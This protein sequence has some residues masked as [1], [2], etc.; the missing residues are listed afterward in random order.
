MRA[1]WKEE[2]FKSMGRR[3]SRVSC[4]FWEWR[5]YLEKLIEEPRH[6]EIK[7]LEILW[8]ACHL[9]KETVPFNVVTKINWR[10]TIAIYDRRIA[11]KD[12]DAAVKAEYI[13]YEGAGTVEF[14]LINTVTSISWKWILYSG[15]TS[16]TESNWLWFNVSKF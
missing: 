5:M 13:K 16:Y 4:R 14:W 11:S 12:G 1:V 8:K 3:S 15:R 2:D 7:L 9:L 6:I 10:N